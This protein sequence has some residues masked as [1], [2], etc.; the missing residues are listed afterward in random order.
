MEWFIK[1]SHILDRLRDSVVGSS[2]HSKEKILYTTRLYLSKNE[3][4]RF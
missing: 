4:T 1:M 2:F 3:H